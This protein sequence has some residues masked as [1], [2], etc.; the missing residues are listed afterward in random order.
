MEAI[1]KDY[2]DSDGQCNSALIEKDVI[3]N[4]SVSRGVVG[5]S[6]RQSLQRAIKY[7]LKYKGI[8]S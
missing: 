7:G 8:N 4:P 1:K 3:F 5:C 6:K 2:V